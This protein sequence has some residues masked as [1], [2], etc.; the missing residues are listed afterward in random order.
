MWQGKGELDP[1]GLMDLY[2]EDEEKR[3]EAGAILNADAAHK[4]LEDMSAADFEKALTEAVRSIRR[5]ALEAEIAEAGP[6]LARLQQ[7]LSEK[8]ALNRLVIHLEEMKR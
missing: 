8:E 1:A 4:S 3:R 7:L 6:D 2:A 5:R